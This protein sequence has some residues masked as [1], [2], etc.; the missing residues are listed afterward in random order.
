MGWRGREKRGTGEAPLRGKR[1]R[2]GG[3]TI[4]RS[5]KLETCI[6]AVG[7]A[8]AKMMQARER[9]RRKGEGEGRD[10]SVEERAKALDRAFGGAR[11]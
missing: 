4:H 3:D 8:E 6:D 11:V 10:N 9:E 2:G 5:V 7:L 1:K